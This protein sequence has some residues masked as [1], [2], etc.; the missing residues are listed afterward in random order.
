M[1]I[2][3]E[4]AQAVHSVYV[5]RKYH[6]AKYSDKYMVHYQ[7]GKITKEEW[8]AKRQVIKDKFPYPA[9]VDKTEALEYVK[10]E[11]GWEIE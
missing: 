6:Y 1:A 9:G 4:E 10:K 11:T 2:K 7:L 5:H 3:L 8:E